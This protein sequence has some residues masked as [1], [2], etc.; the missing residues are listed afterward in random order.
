MSRRREGSAPRLLAAAL[1]GAAI[2]TAPPAAG[3]GLEAVRALASQE[4]HRAARVAFDALPAETRAAPGARLLDGVLKV[5]EG[6]VDEAAGIFD[7]LVSGH[8]DRPEARINLALLDAARLG[9]RTVPVKLL[10]DEIEGERRRAE[11]WWVLR[12][13]YLRL[14]V[15]AYARANA[16]DLGIDPRI[17]PGSAPHETADPPSRVAPL[18]M[19]FSQV[20]PLAVTRD[21]R[22]GPESGTTVASPAGGPG[23][24]SSGS[25]AAGPTLR[26]PETHSAVADASGVT[27]PRGRTGAVAEPAPAD[28]PPPAEGG[29]PAGADLRRPGRGE[30]LP[31]PE[32]AG[33]ND[34]VRHAASSHLEAVADG[35]AARPS[36]N[37]A[38]ASRIRAR[39]RAGP[40]P[41]DQASSWR[42]LAKAIAFAVGAVAVLASIA[43]GIAILIRG[44]GPD[45]SFRR[46]LQRVAAPLVGPV[47]PDGPAEEESIFRPLEK[48]SRLSGLWDRI[49]ARYPLLRA[50][51]AFPA[52]FGAALAG[53]GGGWF[54]MWFLKVPFGW[55]SMP[56]AGV[57]GM[58]AAWY[59][60]AWLQSRQ[61][62]EFVRQFPEIVDQIVRLSGA[63]LPPLEAVSAVA[64]D[65]QDPVKPILGGVRDG[66]LAG[67]NPESTLRTASNRVRL[68]EF[69]LFAAVIR[70]QRRA[71]GGIS[72]AFSNLAETLRER[73]KTA[74]RAHAS[75]AQS[76]L[77]LLVLVLMPVVVLVAQKFIAPQSVEMLFGTETGLSLL[78]WGVALIVA[79]ILIARQIA[80]RAVR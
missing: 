29:G 39:E 36:A 57:A 24:S 75:T 49:E 55:W 16:I 70:L 19:P 35:L 8:P 1:A 46:R 42:A 61:E 27:V 63:G 12:D 18:R 3:A 10:D 43:G 62:A 34:A 28:R 60:L 25:F 23:D 67:L 79:G 32:G 5:R 52:A 21:G 45:R 59:V 80:A 68:G 13:L 30:A 50:R 31:R 11:A 78:R 17:D 14:T 65:T 26:A 58:A 15:S 41:D 53:A 20:F 51:Q 38:T 9:V 48:P 77:T 74:L 47:V 54:A 7:E 56:V 76:R 2:L 4:R 40:T 64:D 22:T 66:L 72:A 44:R 73:R 69:T 33:V 6:S 37:V 71:G